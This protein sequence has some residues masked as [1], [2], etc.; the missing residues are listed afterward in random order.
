M[1][2]VPLPGAHGGDGARVAE[3]L[4]LDPE[5]VLDLSA[6]F[7][8]VAPDAAEIV[9]KHLDRVRTYPDPGTA[10]AAL[11][12]AIGVERERVLLTNGGAEA[13]ALVAADVGA[14]WVDEPDF[15]LYRRHLASVTPGAPRWRSNPHNPTGRLAAEAER[16]AVW[17]EAFY[18]LATGAWTRGDADRGAVVVGSLT[19]VFSCPG[20]RLGYV[21]AP[22]EETARRLA[23]R[24]PR[25][26]VNGLA[27]SAVPDLL[28][29]ADLAAWASAVAALRADL[30]ALLA[31]HGL[32]PRPSEANYV[33][34]GGAAGLRDRLAPRG[35]VVRDC[36]SF[37]LP[38]FARIAVPD[39]HGLGRLAAALEPASSG[40]A[41]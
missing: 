31:A 19:K 23:E 20:L 22:D 18:G 26:S 41:P 7:N 38:G 34:V 1:R 24:Q 32:Q 2:S 37:G 36:S 28:A 17:D 16:A 30:V 8:P 29:R 12:E 21:L 35:V 13:I 11:A 33:L 10:T 3:A 25:W 5:G 9:G 6:S 15:G 14:G 27:A 39:A 40:A 4:G